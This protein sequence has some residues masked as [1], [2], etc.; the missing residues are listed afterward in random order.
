MSGH[1]DWNDFLIGTFQISVQDPNEGL[2][3]TSNCTGFIFVGFIIWFFRIWGT[4]YILMGILFSHSEEVP[5]DLNFA[6]NWLN[7]WKEWN[8]FD[9]YLMWIRN[10][11][12]S[13]VTN[14]LSLLVYV[15]R[16]NVK[17]IWFS[18]VGIQ[19]QCFWL[20]CWK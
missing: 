2:S 8:N 17:K 11:N 5:R 6:S 7:T 9:V 16:I 13:T 4:M 3:I 19:T 1:H 14:N 12:V 18:L 10:S 15:V 20:S